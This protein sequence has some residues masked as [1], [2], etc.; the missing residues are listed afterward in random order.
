MASGFCIDSPGGRDENSEN[1][2]SSPC[3]TGEIVVAV[4][5][6]EGLTAV[7]V[8]GLTAVDYVVG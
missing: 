1:M 3:W 5:T 7:I 4:V 6:V 2:F 8:V